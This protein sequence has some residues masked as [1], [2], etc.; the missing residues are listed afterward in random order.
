M[1]ARF[2]TLVACVACVACIAAAGTAA[3]QVPQVPLID[4]AARRAALAGT[5]V[6]TLGRP[7]PFVTVSVDGK[8]LSAVTDNGGRFHLGGVPAGR[9]AFSV[10]RV[11]YK[12]LNFE[13]TLPPDSTIVI[14]IRLRS[15]QTLPDVNVTSQRQSPR[16]A[17]DGFYDRQRVGWGKYLSPED[18]DS[19]S[20]M[21]STPAQLMRN[22]NGVRVT[23]GQKERRQ[24]GGCVVEGAPPSYCMVVFID[25]VYRRGQIDELLSPGA[26]YALEVY[27]RAAVVPVEY[28]HP[29]TERCGAIIAWTHS[30]RP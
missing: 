29:A 7:L 11:G 6:D 2:L 12:A 8:D 26:V 13:V 20:A 3:A 30:R 24:T 16:L 10:M 14:D 23:C 1:L 22:M 9:N 28:K 15:A 25:G 5:V 27:N 21:V 18:V 19:L 17:R 4:P